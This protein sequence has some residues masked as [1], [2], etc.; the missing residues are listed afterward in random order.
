MLDFICMGPVDLIGAR[1]KRQNTKWKLPCPQWD[2]NPQPFDSKS[3]A[4]PTE[5]AGLVNA[6]RL[7]GPITFM[8]SQYQCLPCYMYQ[9]DEEERNLS[10]N[11]NRD[12][13]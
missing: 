2:L 3:D 12:F 5:L 7:N 9:N 8:Y 1:R 13:Y 10:C 6:V 4:L 11:S